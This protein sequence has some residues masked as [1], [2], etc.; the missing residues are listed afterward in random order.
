MA[1]DKAAIGQRI[2]R[3]RIA[4]GY[5]TQRSFAEAVG[6]YLPNVNRWEKGHS[7]PDLEQ[8]LRICDLTGLS[9]EQ[10]LLGSGYGA[11]PPGGETVR[12]E[13]LKRLFAS[14]EGKRLTTRQRYAL[15]EFL[16]GIEVDEWRAKAAMELLLGS[17]TNPQ[18]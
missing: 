17:S 3:A 11:V 1:L 16:D 8:L 18:K 4:A 2:K 6:V 15:A 9:Q 14:E 10:I 12:S 5:T 7:L 13:G